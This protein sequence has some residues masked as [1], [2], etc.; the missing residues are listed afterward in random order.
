LVLADKPVIV[1]ES[2]IVEFRDA[3]FV[4]V[5]VE[6]GKPLFVL[7]SKL[8][9][10]EV[11]S[12]FTEPFSVACQGEDVLTADAA[13]VVTTMFCDAETAEDKLEVVNVDGAPGSVASNSL[14]SS[15]IPSFRVVTISVSVCPAS[16]ST[17]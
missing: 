12:V 4:G 10:R 14:S 7:Y 9:V 5:E 16:L 11:E 13:I 1:A 17:S 8:H 6:V 3:D 15:P 2:D